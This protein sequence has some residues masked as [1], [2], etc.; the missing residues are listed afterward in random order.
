MN[1]KLALTGEKTLNKLAGEYGVLAQQARSWKNELQIRAAELFEKKNKPHEIDS[2]QKEEMTSPLF[3]Q[4]GQLKIE[5]D[6]LKK[7]WYPTF[8]PY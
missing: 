8:E 4:I 7:S 1:L 6:W 5:N 3:Q 2:V